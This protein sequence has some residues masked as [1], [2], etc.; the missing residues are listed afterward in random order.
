MA[1]FRWALVSSSNHIIS[2]KTA[3]KTSQTAPPSPEV[4]TFTAV[5]TRERWQWPDNQQF[6]II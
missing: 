4:F 6:Q 3:L 1:S 5:N 2:P